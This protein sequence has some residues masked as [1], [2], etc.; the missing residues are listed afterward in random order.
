MNLNLNKLNWKKDDTFSVADGIFALIV[1]YTVLWLIAK[2]GWNIKSNGNL[3]IGC[4]IV[5]IL[6]FVVPVF[7][8]RTGK[9][10]ALTLT[11]LVSMLLSAAMFLYA[12]WINLPTEW[13]KNIYTM[14]LLVVGWMPMVVLIAVIIAYLF[15]RRRFK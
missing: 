2:M 14:W 8:K 10:W 4:I 1:G 12:I 15:V 3:I 5:I 9:S 13:Q 11:K 7:V 6:L